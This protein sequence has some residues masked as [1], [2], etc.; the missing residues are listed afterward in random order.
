[1][2][3]ERTLSAWNAIGGLIGWVAWMGLVF[4]GCLAW[5]EARPTRGTARAFRI[6]TWVAVAPV[7]AAT[8]EI[9]AG[10]IQTFVRETIPEL[11]TVGRLLAVE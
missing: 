1:M 6:L 9:V 2:K 3:S 5:F 8:L 7:S 10:T 11:I 4:A